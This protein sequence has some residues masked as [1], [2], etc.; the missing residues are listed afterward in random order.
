MVILVQLDRPDHQVVMVQLVNLG[1]LEMMASQEIVANGENQ[2]QADQWD[3]Q[4]YLDFPELPVSK[5]LRV[6]PVS[7]DHSDPEEILGLLDLM[8]TLVLQEHLYV[9]QSYQSIC[10]SRLSCRDCVHMLTALYTG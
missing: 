2:A 10:R 3:N 1:T 8:A 9:R 4:V 5:A 7:K 6:T